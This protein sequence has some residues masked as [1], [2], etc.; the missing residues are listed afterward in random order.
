MCYLPPSHHLEIVNSCHKQ[1]VIFVK[2]PHCSK[3]PTIRLFH[4]VTC[5]ST[6]TTP[7][8]V[9]KIE[10]TS[11]S[12]L[13]YTSCKEKSKQDALQIIMIYVTN[14]VPGFPEPSSGAV[15]CREYQSLVYFDSFSPTIDRSSYFAKRLH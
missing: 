14:Y 6:T 5:S 1:L 15:L 3:Q 13:L 9:S 7:C 10:Y 4:V 12:I 11:Y 2:H 8:V